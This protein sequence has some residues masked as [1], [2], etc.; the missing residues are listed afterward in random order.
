MN[1]I[2]KIICLVTW[3]DTPTQVDTNS[4]FGDILDLDEFSGGDLCYQ[5]Q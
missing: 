1:S 2:Q 5:Q 4:N 3:E